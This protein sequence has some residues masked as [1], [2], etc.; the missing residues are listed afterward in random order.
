MVG[1]KDFEMPKKCNDCSLM[2]TYAYGRQCTVTSTKINRGYI[3]PK[4]CPLVEIK[5]NEDGKDEK[6]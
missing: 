3:K 4:D 2:V 5:E 1:I 6:D